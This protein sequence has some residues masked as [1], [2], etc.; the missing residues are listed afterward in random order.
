[1]YFDRRELKPYAEP[2]SA[3]A[4]HERTIYFFLN[5]MD[6]KMLVPSMDPMVFVGRNLDAGDTERVYF[7][8]VDSFSRGVRYGD[9]SESEAT[10][11]SGSATQ[12]GHIFE[13]ERALDLLLACS[14]RRRRHQV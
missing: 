14:L 3:D 13:F 7:Q 4:L 12:L 2:V 10:F 8:D 6:D 9:D 1:M 11:Y 5:F